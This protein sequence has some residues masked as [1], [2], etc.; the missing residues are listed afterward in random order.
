P[1]AEEAT[2]GPSD[3][4]SGTSRPGRARTRTWAAAALGVVVSTLLATA[5]TTYFDV[6]SSS[7]S[8]VPA[9]QG[10]HVESEVW[11]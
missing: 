3:R 4:S 5:V 2:E 8:P 10:L 9:G 6:W 1:A 7:R 11:W